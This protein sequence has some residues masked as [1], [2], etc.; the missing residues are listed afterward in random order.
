MRGAGTQMGR[1][2]SAFTPQEVP[3]LSCMPF[4]L[5]LH[6]FSQ[7]PLLH[8]PHSKSQILLCLHH[9]PTQVSPFSQ[10]L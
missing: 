1:H 6:L 5:C 7:L 8:L 9:A 4:Y 3:A 10:H 2:L